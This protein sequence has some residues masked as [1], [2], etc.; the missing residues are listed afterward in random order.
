MALGVVLLVA[1]RQRRWQRLRTVA[2]NTLIAYGTVVVMLAAGEVFFRYLY[3]DTEGRLASRNWEDRYWQENTLGYRDR[4]WEPVDWADKQ[5][6]L[7][8]GDS[9]TAG[10]G[11][12]DPADRFPDVLARLLGDDYAVMNV[13][14]RGSSTAQQLRMLDDYPVQEPDVILWQYFLNDI[15][16]AALSV[17]LGAIV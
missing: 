9:F 14:A 8:L 11:I 16:E 7:A 13:G 15:E 5:T 6:I 1:A 17:G 10:W 4:E 3:H 2:T 12:D